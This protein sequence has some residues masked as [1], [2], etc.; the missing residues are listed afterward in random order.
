M[1]SKGNQPSRDLL[2]Q[3][4]GGGEGGG[5]LRSRNRR[6][7]DKSRRQAPLISSLLGLKFTSAR[8]DWKC[9]RKTLLIPTSYKLNDG[10]SGAL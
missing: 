6:I 3:A 5:D 9:H 4:E 1:L 2:T 7:F 8:D 10:P